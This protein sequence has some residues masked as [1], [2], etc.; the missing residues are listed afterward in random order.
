MADS[1][2]T[3]IDEKGTPRYEVGLIRDE[4][5][6]YYRTVS[7]KADSREATGSKAA[8]IEALLERKGGVLSSLYQDKKLLP[9]PVPISV[10][11]ELVIESTIL[12]QLIDAYVNNEAGGGFIIETKEDYDEELSTE[13]EKRQKYYTGFFQQ[14]NEN[15]NMPSLRRKLRYS[16]ESTGNGYFEVVDDKLGF[17][18]L[19]YHLNSVYMRIGPASQTPVPVEV[20]FVRGD[21]TTTMVVNKYFRKY[22]MIIPSREMMTSS[23][24][25]SSDVGG[26]IVWFKEFGDP[27]PMDMYTGE[28]NE[29]PK[30]PASSV[31]HF[32]GPIE[33][34]GYGL[35]RWF[36]HSFG[37]KGL[38]AADFVNYDLFDNQT[39]PPW[40]IMVSGGHLTKESYE[41]VT[42]LLRSRK[43]VRNFNKTMVLESVPVQKSLDGK[44]SSAAAKIESVPLTAFRENDL[45]FGEYIES[46]EKRI[47]TSY[48][49][50]PLYLGRSDDLTRAT[51]FTSFSMTELQ[52]FK[53]L[54][55]DPDQIITNTIIRLTDADDRLPGDPGIFVYRS[56]GLEFGIGPETTTAFEMLVEQGIITY[57][58]AAKVASK[59]LSMTITIPEEDWVDE[60]LMLVRARTEVQ[61]GLL[62]IAKKLRMKKEA[63]EIDEDGL[64]E[65]ERSLYAAL[66][67]LEEVGKEFI[68]G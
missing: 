20:T 28:Y 59:L 17:P 61:E 30:N 34:E 50:N 51:A 49:L 14:I 6:N 8:S 55:A 67:R 57:S 4:L 42:G 41:E 43:G 27:R 12:P 5:T 65:Q 64:T 18:A 58:Q 24:V 9:P 11:S 10:L 44:D 39:I 48:R 22:A 32:K 47:R 46:T 35:P 63:G 66:L 19:I 68:Y 33:S 36:G 54:R 26:G 56:L 38:A 45:M 1:Q 25:A 60:P 23:I 7:E 29:S 3:T 37:I 53:F 62:K 15:E 31:I 40:L 2:N 52:V 21:I 13:N 16:I